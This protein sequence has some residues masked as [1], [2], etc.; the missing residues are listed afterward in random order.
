MLQG[1]RAVIWLYQSPLNEPIQISENN[2]EHLS[3]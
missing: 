1:K 3:W 2:I